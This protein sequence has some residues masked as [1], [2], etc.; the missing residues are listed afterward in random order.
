MGPI[1]LTGGIVYQRSQEYV[2]RIA[3]ILINRGIIQNITTDPVPAEYEIMDVRGLHIV[4]GMVDSH[5][6]GGDRSNFSV[7][8]QHGEEFF[9]RPEMI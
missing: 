4:P 5:N 2:P 3:T 6:H 8:V 9:A 7:G 1:A